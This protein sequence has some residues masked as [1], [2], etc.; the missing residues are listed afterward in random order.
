MHADEEDRSGPSTSPSAPIRAH[1]RS[2]P[3]V[4][5][6]MKRLL[7]VLRVVLSMGLMALLYRR[8]DWSQL[9]GI[10]AGARLPLVVLLYALLLLNTVI[11]AVKW[12][13]LLQ[14][15]RVAVPL[16][17]L[18]VS[19]LIGSFLNLFLPSS[20]GGDAYRIYD[21]AQYGRAAKSFASVL[22]DRLTG[23]IALVV[24]GFAFGLA[25]YGAL[26]HKQV[27]LIPALAMAALLS[28]IA[29]L[30]QRRLLVRI[31]EATP[32]RRSAKLRAFLDGLLDS[33]AEYRRA[34]GLFLRIM[35]L[36]FLFQLTA[37]ACILILARALGYDTP[38]LYFFIF[39]PFISL[40][41]ALPITIFGLGLRDGLYVF[42]F[43]PVGMTQTAALTLALAY[44]LMTVVYC[45]SGGL[46]LLLRWKP[47]RGTA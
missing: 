42:F 13:W 19:Y 18:V 39:V 26:P 43:T 21:V 23:F 35:G 2:G 15:D 5:V 44:V 4:F 12:R 27:F 10:L 7:P 33:V 46:L 45:L 1:P 29:L 14:A 17:R 30:V 20:I 32:A 31:F 37:I 25:G 3:A 47:A 22:A 40:M 38:A 41:E 6:V 11:S 9:G 24:L 36:S 34:P 16:P 8:M 28:G